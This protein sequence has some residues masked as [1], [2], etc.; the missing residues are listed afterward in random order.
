MKKTAK[1]LLLLIVCISLC[2]VLSNPVLAAAKKPNKPILTSV[3]E[4]SSGTVQINWKKAK[5]AQKYEIQVSVNG[6]KYKKLKTLKGLTFIHTK[7]KVGKTYAYKVR[8]IN[9]TKKSKF[10]KIKK[11]KIKKSKPTPKRFS[12]TQELI[13]NDWRRIK[14]AYSSA[15]AS[16]AY[17]I[18]YT[19]LDGDDC[20]ITYIAYSIINRYKQTMYHNFTKGVNTNNMDSYFSNLERRQYGATLVHTY[21][22]HNEA[23][24][25]Y[26]A[27][28]SG[29]GESV[30]AK[31]LNSMF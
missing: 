30:P 25:M 1:T 19:N 3:K 22:L 5:N 18:R 13:G 2:A 29:K 6:G 23:L 27:V 20:L 7:L 8:A 16:L 24:E 11:I 21:D 15:T 12:Q 10:S 31:T 14:N 28:L 17:G 9:G 4:I 26:K